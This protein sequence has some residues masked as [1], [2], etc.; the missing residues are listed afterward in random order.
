M[1]VLIKTLIAGFKEGLGGIKGWLVCPVKW[2]LDYI[3]E[4]KGV[5]IYTLGRSEGMRKKVKMTL[6]I[7]QRRVTF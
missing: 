1:V 7:N 4:G 2:A 3:P 5:S 6:N